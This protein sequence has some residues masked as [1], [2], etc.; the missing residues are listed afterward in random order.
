MLFR[1]NG[2]GQFTDVAMAAGVAYT[3]DGK[4]FSG[5]GA[6]FTDLDNRGL[7]DILATALPYEYYA[8]F[9]NL[10]KGQFNYSSVSAGLA[11]ATRPFGGWGIQAFDYDNDGTKEIFLANAHV[12]DNIEVTQPHLRTLEPPL[13]LRYDGDRF[14]DISAAAG[15]VFK[16]AWAARGAAFGDLDNDGDIDIVVT[17]LHAAAHLLRN[18]GGSRNH[19]I[20]LHLRG[21]TRNRDAIGAQV[22]LT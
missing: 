18:E 11:L 19:W 2:N 20:G 1:N 21:T 9:R 17:D 10:G 12:M 16:S 6:I 15:D 22:P 14:S 13:L 3:E 5:M 8:L 4:T 7:P